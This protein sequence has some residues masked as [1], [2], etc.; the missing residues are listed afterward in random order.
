MHP[1]RQL[2]VARVREFYREPEAIFWVYV[3]PVLLAVGLGIAFRERPPAQ[4]R[5][6]VVS[7]AG[8]NATG[9][10][11]GGANATGVADGGAK[12]TVVADGDE[13]AAS[14]TAEALASDRFLVTR[15]GADE[16]AGRLRMGRSDLT[17]IPGKPVQFLYDPIRPESV[18]ARARVDDALQRAAG[19]VDP[20]ATADR[21][22][23]E[24]G[25]RYIDFL[26]PGLL[27]MNLM[28]GGLWGVGF[29]IVDMRVRKLLKRLVATPM[30]KGHFLIAMLGSRILFMLPEL[31]LLLMAGTLLFG[32]AVRGS[33][34][35]VMAVSALGAISF[36]GLGLLVAC[37]AKKIETVA[38]LMN[39]VM[40][41]MWL[42]SG[43]F[44]SSDRFPASAQPFIRALPLTMLNDALRAI[45]LEGATLL[46]QG[47]RLAGLAAW[48]VISF[49]AALRWFR[50]S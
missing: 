23:T 7:Q 37:R 22:V 20:I 40:L 42:L 34:I 45:I 48:G 33:Y 44:F 43:I 8:A 31:V 6:D 2:L 13:E 39:V 50:W 10:A 49:L 4:I 41:P 3:F 35:A 36:A 30:R 21:L 14:R 1:L 26:I 15:C 25:S 28:G 5:V 18:L 24:P 17:V 11:D 16:C 9:V 38:G 32:V 46:S 12:A 27:G 47:A 29:V 19:R